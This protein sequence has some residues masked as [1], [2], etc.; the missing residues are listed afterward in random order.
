[1]HVGIFRLDLAQKTLKSM[2]AIDEDSVLTLLAT[3]TVHIATVR[4]VCV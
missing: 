2:K 1:M 3:A 4:F